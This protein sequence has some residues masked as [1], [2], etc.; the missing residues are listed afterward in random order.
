MPELWPI[1][2]PED[3]ELIRQKIRDLPFDKKKDLYAALQHDENEHIKAP[4]IHTKIDNEM[5]RY[6]KE[7]WPLMCGVTRSNKVWFI[8]QW[9]RI[10][11]YVIK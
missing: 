9:S 4:E 7:M 10:P 1:Q 5:L 2:L 6:T 11:I 3:L 8:G